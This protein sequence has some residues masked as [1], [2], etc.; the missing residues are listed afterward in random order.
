MHSIRQIEQ[1]F[2]DQL[3]DAVESFVAGA[4]FKYGWP[5]NKNLGYSHWNYTIAPGSA[6][7]GLEIAHMLP[8]PIRSAWNYIQE[9]YTGEQT[10]IRCYANAHT[11]GVEGYPH[12]DSIREHDKTIVVYMNREWR[13][14]WGG[15]TML[16][17]GDRIEHAELPKFNKGLVFNGNQYHTARSVS[18]ICPELRRT[19]M[20]KFAPR[21][22]DTQRD[23]IQAF[24]THVGA[25]AIKHSGRTLSV[26]LINTYDILK[27]HGHPDYVCAAGGMHSIFGTNIFKSA[28]VSTEHRDIVAKIIGKEALELVELFRDIKRPET[29]EQAVKNKVLTVET[30]DGKTITLTESQLNNLCAI[31]AANLS[32]QKG[33]KNW[34]NISNF[35]KR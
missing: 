6:F 10:L 14:E 13:R 26:H 25:D 29:L 9:H 19:L 32:D 20:F 11:F 5:S 35:L 21:N 22:I 4:P 34:P 17:D 27:K 7:N 3:A 28:T 24:L 12:T 8:E 1:V 31:E 2:P 18:R 23:K 15:E 33:L 16:Y 30:N